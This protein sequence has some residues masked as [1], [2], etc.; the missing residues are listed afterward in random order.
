MSTPFDLSIVIPCH[1]ESDGLDEL[2][3]QL[4]AAL[5]GLRQT[6]TVE[7]LLIDDGS[8]DDTLE[9]LHAVFGTWQDV[10]IVPHGRNLGLA[11]ALRTGA[12]NTTGAVI[13]FTDSDC[14]YPPATIAGLLQHMTP[15]VDIVTSSAY[16]PEGGVE[17]VPAYR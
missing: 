5:A 1:N 13:V 6:R 10:R 2:A 17:G 4:G 8:T 15:D 16:H 14:T 9:R 11:A 7:L 12:A 3:I